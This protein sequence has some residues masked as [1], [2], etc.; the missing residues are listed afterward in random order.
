MKGACLG[1]SNSAALHIK[2]GEWSRAL[3][4]YQESLALFERLEDLAGAAR[5]WQIWASS[6]RE[7]RNHSGQRAVVQGSGEV[8]Q[9]R[10]PG[11]C[12]GDA[13][14]IDLLAKGGSEESPTWR[15]PLQ[16]QSLKEAEIYPAR[17]RCSACGGYHADRGR[18]DEGLSCY[19]ESLEL[20]A[21]VGESFNRASVLFNMALVYK[22]R[23]IWPGR[24]HCSK[25]PS[26]Y[27][28][29]W[30]L[31]PAWPRSISPGLGAGFAGP[32]R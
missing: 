26:P 30:R 27:F 22:D 16:I 3:Q 20:F 7:R 9:H 12:G 28:R 2:K 31:F 18:W 10:R 8:P 19:Q 25:K 11:G 15:M 29:K 17:Q 14:N 23:G 1:L 6:T 4:C 24:R 13:A 32:G 21:A 5:C